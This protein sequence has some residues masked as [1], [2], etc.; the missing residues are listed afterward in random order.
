[1]KRILRF[2]PLLLL[3]VFLMGCE[4]QSKATYLTFGDQAVVFV[5]Q[6]SV[7]TV[8]DM[9]SRVVESYGTYRDITSA[10]A[11]TTM[12]PIDAEA[13]YEAPAANLKRIM[14][15]L[16]ALSRETEVSQGWGALSAV[17]KQAKKSTLPEVLESL[18][19]APGL[20]KEI[21]KA[22]H[23][24]HLD[25]GQVLPDKIDWEQTGPWLEVWFQGALRAGRRSD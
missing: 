22:K 23:W 24:V 8:I 19:Q 18:A 10:E 15:L 20:W 7:L 5:R 3:M 9:P 2:L 14:L 4:Q 6:G 21:G 1:M 11:I 12:L 13:V 25:L 16:S 17:R